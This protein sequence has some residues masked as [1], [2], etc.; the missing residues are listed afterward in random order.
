M[1]TI[2]LRAGAMAPPD[3]E[4]GEHVLAGLADC[5]VLVI[6]AGGLGCEIL[7]NLAL[8][9]FKNVHVIDMDTIDLSNLNR[10]FLFRKKDVGKPK[11]V[12]AAEFVN[13]RVPGANIKAYCAK[14]QDYD[15]E[16]YRQFRFVIAGLDSIQARRWINGQLHSMLVFD[17]DDLD[18]SSIIPLIDGGSEGFKGQARVIIPGMTSCFECSMALV[19]PQ[20]TYPLCTIT[21]TPRI[22][23]HCIK[24]ASALAWPR[25]HPDEALDMDIPEHVDWVFKVASERAAEFK[26]PGVTRM[27]TTGVVKNIIPAIASTNAIIAAACTNEALKLAT[28]VLPLMNNYMYFNGAQGI[29][30]YTYVYEKYPDCFV[31]S[32][33][34]IQFPIEGT[35]TLSELMKML[36]E[37]QRFQFKAPTITSK[38]KSLYFQSPES[39]RE[40]TAPNL[41]KSLQELVENGTMIEVTD[42]AVPLAS[43]GG[44]QLILQW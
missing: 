41:A 32:N 3:F 19:T 15:A 4:P 33:H 22:P 35:K 25:E 16:W 26:I 10:Q 40:A 42:P 12:V 8:S 43:G 14:I 30:T 21:N 7:K 34:P 28:S 29:Y 36:E 27:L 11:A 31:C 17:G 38:A 2:A 13:S 37:D 1:E 23:E 39:M 24:W 20:V 44:V 9:G 5:A 18:P 6:G